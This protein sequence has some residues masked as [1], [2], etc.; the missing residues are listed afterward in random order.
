VHEQNP[1]DVCGDEEQWFCTGMLHNT[2]VNIF[3]FVQNL[4]DC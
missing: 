4:E 1:S 2:T 3:R